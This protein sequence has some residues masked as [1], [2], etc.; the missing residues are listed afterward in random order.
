[1]LVTGVRV[2]S[3]GRGVGGGVGGGPAKGTEVNAS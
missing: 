2:G 1:M 3:G